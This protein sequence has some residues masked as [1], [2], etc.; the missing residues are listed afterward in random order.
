MKEI[1]I[2]FN[3]DTKEWSNN[4]CKLYMSCIVG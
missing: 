2:A 4:K 3:E 1:S